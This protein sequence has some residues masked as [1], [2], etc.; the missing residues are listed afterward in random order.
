MSRHE[1]IAVQGKKGK[2]GMARRSDPGLPQLGTKLEQA[3]LSA[4]LSIAEVARS[5]SV[6]R[7]TIKRW[8][9]GTT[10]VAANDLLRLAMLYGYT[11]IDELIGPIADLLPADL[12]PNRP[13]E[14]T[15][16]AP[17]ELLE[18]AISGMT[19]EQLDALVEAER[20]KRQRRRRARP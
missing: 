1:C 6:D 15:R 18:S 11:S 10:K 9:D 2:D 5:L 7:N 17:R 12:R 20:R 19:D 13:G 4:G 3:R 16:P 8:E 14:D